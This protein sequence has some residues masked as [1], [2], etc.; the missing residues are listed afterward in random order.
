MVWWQRCDTD[1]C[2]CSYPLVHTGLTWNNSHL[3]G[4]H[5][6][7]WSH[8]LFL[9]LILFLL[10]L[11]CLGLPLSWFTFRFVEVHQ[12]V[13]WQRVQGKQNFLRPFM[14]ENGLFPFSCYLIVWLGIEFRL[15]IMSLQ[16]FESIARCVFVFS[17]AIKST[18]ILIF[19]C[20]Q[21]GVCLFVEFT[22]CPV[23][24]IF[25]VI[26]LGMGVFLSTIVDPQGVISNW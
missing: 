1:H 21:R 23:F 19:V 15:E 11:L 10:C 18:V 9:H 16:N 4:D 26:F 3:P 12:P 22:F 2:Q 8:R 20:E 17:I 6:S 25:I 7:V 14:S 13:H 24:W 5:N